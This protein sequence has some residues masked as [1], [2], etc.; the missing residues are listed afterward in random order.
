M[1]ALET[2]KSGDLWKLFYQWLQWAKG[3]AYSNIFSE[4]C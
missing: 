4:V 1:I 2:V 3:F